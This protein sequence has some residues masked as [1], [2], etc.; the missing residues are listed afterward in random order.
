MKKK[1]LYAVALVL[2][3]LLAGTASAD[4]SRAKSLATLSFC[5]GTWCNVPSDCY[6]ACPGGAGS[7]YCDRVHHE[8]YPY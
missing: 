2:S 5:P 7:S 6:A 1:C 4:H 3:S 8:C